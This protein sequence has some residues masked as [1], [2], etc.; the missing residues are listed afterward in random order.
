MPITST[1]QWKSIVLSDDYSTSSYISHWVKLMVKHW[2]F[3]WECLFLNVYLCFVQLN[4]NMENVLFLMC[5][6][7]DKL[8]KIYWRYLIIYVPDVFNERYL[9]W[10]CYWKTYEIVF[11]WK[12]VLILSYF[13]I[14]NIWT[15]ILENGYMCE[16]PI[17]EIVYLI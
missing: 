9:K 7:I 11:F 10:F 13:Y 4:R 17:G 6:V 2:L 8:F 3:G 5:S 1:L 15:L 12:K 16:M 14:W